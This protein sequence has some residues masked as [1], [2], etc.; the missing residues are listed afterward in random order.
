MR[1]IFLLMAVTF[2]QACAFAKSQSV[3][4]HHQ[5]EANLLSV[6]IKN[7]LHECFKVEPI[8]QAVVEDQIVQIVAI[9]SYKSVGYC[10]CPSRV[11]TVYSDEVETLLRS[12][13]PSLALQQGT[14]TFKQSG[15][16]QVSLGT[17]AQLI[18]K[19]ALILSFQCQGP[20]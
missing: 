19:P 3:N 12:Q 20:Q 5:A 18:N 16:Y 2:I 15:T 1:L 6:T 9:Q 10:G 13:V 11:L 7:P 4:A 8:K 14:L 17:R